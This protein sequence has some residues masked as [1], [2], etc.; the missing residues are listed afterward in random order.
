MHPL[1]NLVFR[2]AVAARS[3]GSAGQG[4]QLLP[5]RPG[6]RVSWDGLAE[7]LE[8]KN[9]ILYSLSNRS[10]IFAAKLGSENGFDIKCISSSK[11][12]W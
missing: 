10:R 6:F 3:K 7:A 1:I 9:H 5:R 2:L 12:P 11:T 4:G 8:V